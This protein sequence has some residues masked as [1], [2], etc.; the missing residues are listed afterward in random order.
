MNITLTL[1]YVEL[2]F[3]IGTWVLLMLWT[4]FAYKASNDSNDAT[5]HQ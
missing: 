3:G 1:E 5:S 4:S 2:A